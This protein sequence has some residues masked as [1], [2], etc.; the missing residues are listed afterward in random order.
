MFHVET[1]IEKGGTPSNA[2]DDGQPK[3]KR[4]RSGCAGDTGRSVEPDRI[5]SSLRTQ[6]LISYPPWRWSA[7]PGRAT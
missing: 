3:R 2:D 7:D 4:S 1:S 6:A 5:S